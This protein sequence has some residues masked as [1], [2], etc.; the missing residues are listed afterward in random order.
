MNF[1]LRLTET[2]HAQLKAHLFPGDGNEAVALLLCGRRKGKT[3][4]I[5]TVQEVVPVPHEAC[6]VRA[7]DLITWPTEYVDRLV[8]SA[9]GQGKAIVKIHSHAEGYRFFSST[10]DRSDRGLFSSISSLLDDGLPHASVIMLPS[11]EMFGRVLDETG[12]RL[13]PLETIMT[14]GT[15]IH[16]WNDAASGALAPF[17]HRHSQAFGSGTISRLGRLS[18]AVV[19]CSGTGSVVIEQLT[20]LGVGNLVLVDPDVVEEKNLNRIVN[21]TRD[22]IGKP[23]VEVLARAISKMGF[24][25]NVHP[26]QADLSSSEALRAVAEC[27]VA[28][29]CVDS[30]EGRHVLNRICTFYLIPYFDVGVRLGPSATTTLFAPSAR[31]ASAAAPTSLGFVFTSAPGMDSTRF[32]FSSTFFPRGSKSN[33]RRPSVSSRSSGPAYE[34]S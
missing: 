16:I 30:L 15:D 4:H 18:I 29:G 5:L 26:I 8:Q 11:G 28:F 20:R 14:A 17:Q 22:D 13:A 31:N 3:R 27:D 24:N 32:G 9:Y 12:V 34:V 7:P 23:K 6:K 10:D 25:Q 33:N 2:H 19:G 1:S 21:S